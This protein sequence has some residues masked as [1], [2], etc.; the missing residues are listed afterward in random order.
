DKAIEIARRIS[1][2]SVPPDVQQRGRRVL[3]EA[4]YWSRQDAAVL[5][6]ADRLS[7]PDPE[8]TL[9]R[10]VSSLRLDLPQAHDLM[11]DLFLHE[12]VSSLHGRAYTFIA[13]EPSYLQKFS[14]RDQDLMAGKN[15]L[16]QG[17][18]S[19]AIP[20][21]EGVLSSIDPSDVADGALVADLGNSYVFA[22]RAAAGAR[23]MEGLAEK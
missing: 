2:S 6:E 13:A 21:L 22:G 11:M 20:L 12:R 9:F 17:D 16:V 18:W 4:L 7:N 3:V 1:S 19:R 23:F 10:A 14:A 5:Q 8:V 15:S